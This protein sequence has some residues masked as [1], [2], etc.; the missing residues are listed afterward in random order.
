MARVWAIITSLWLNLIEKNAVKKDV[1][2]EEQIYLIALYVVSNLQDR[3]KSH[4]TYNTQLTQLKPMAALAVL[5]LP[6][7]PQ[8]N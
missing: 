6:T 2:Q 3:Q 7:H 1:V 4:N 8:R 5:K